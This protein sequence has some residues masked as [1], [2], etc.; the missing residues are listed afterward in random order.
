MQ[1][2]FQPTV[3]IM[4]SGQNGTLYVGVTSNLPQRVWQHRE[5]LVDG[6]TA[7]YGCKLL[8][9]FEQHA[10][11]E[12]AIAREAAEGGFASQEAG[13]DRTGQS[14]L[15]G[16]VRLHLRLTPRKSW[17]PPPH[18]REEPQATRRSKGHQL[19]P[20]AQ[21][22]VAALAMTREVSL[23]PTSSSRG[24]AGDAAIQ[25]TGAGPTTQHFPT[26]P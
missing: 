15:A 21:D 18:P 13:A 20:A 14:Q 2:H 17:R 16:P 24:A 22:R 11:M 12:Y 7:R 23:S 3:Y 1:R 19:G 8:V 5:A 26:R 4:A 10:T 9:W 25:A 6:F